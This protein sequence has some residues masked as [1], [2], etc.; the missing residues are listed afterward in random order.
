M[1]AVLV[2]SLGVILRV[3]VLAHVMKM[4]GLKVMMGRRLVMGGRLM[5]MFA[6]RMLVLRH[7]VAPV[8]FSG[9]PHSVAASIG[10][11]FPE[12]APELAFRQ[13][14]ERNEDARATEA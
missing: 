13:S 14:A 8:E 5:M 7:D 10:R 1:L 3:L 12:L 2:S 4:G 9:Q 11:A 6:R